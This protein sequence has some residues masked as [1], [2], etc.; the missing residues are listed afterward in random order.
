M[1]H[2]WKTKRRTATLIVVA[3]LVLLTGTYGLIRIARQRANR[4]RQ[5]ASFHARRAAMFQKSIISK[6]RAARDCEA[7]GGERMLQV[8]SDYRAE[9]ELCAKLAVYHARLIARYE[10]AAAHPWLPVGSD[11][12]EPAH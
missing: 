3:I 4:F 5:R 1:P 6:E 12:P 8:A 7:Y 11:P 9:V 10:Q 2:P